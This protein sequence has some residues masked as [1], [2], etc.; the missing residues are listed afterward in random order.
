MCGGSARCS[1][2][3]DNH[4]LIYLSKTLSSHTAPAKQFLLSLPPF[5]L[6]LSSLSSITPPPPASPQ[7]PPLSL[8]LSV[9]NYNLEGYF[10][11]GQKHSPQAL[12]LLSDSHFTPPILSARF[13]FFFSLPLSLFLF[14][15]LLSSAGDFFW[16]VE[17]NKV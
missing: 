6:L 10:S 7:P 2:T 13:F 15:T 4:S 11:P 1:V 17:M 9:S 12:P 3:V 16:R 14:F 5:S 8:F